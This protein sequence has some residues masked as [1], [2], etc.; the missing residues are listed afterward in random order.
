MPAPIHNS[1]LTLKKGFAVQSN[2]K[3]HSRYEFPR[4]LDLRKYLDGNS[5]HVNDTTAYVLQVQPPFF[6]RSV[7]THTDTCRA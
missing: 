4:E 7:L 3:I 1:T 5:P 6:F 2:D